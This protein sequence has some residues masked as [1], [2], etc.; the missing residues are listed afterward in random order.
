MPSLTSLAGKKNKK[1]KVNQDIFAPDTSFKNIIQ[2][3][4]LK[5]SKENKHPNR[6]MVNEQEQAFCKRSMGV[7]YI[8]LKPFKFTNN[9]INAN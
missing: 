7:I 8:I 5:N 6:K 3:E 1:Q 9:Q 4:F 2:K